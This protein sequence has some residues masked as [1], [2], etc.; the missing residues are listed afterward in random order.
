MRALQAALILI[1]IHAAGDYA[2]QAVAGPTHVN[3]LAQL[4]Y[5][6][7][8]TSAHGWNLAATVA[9]LLMLTALIGSILLCFHRETNGEMG[10][11][12]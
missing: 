4:M 9:I 11:K 3:S 5:R 7:Q 1:F 8:H 10:A 12:Q 2:F 6:L